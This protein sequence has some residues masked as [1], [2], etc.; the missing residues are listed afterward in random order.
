MPLRTVTH[1]LT[2]ALAQELFGA[3]KGIGDGA[4]RAQAAASMLAAV[5]LEEKAECAAGTLSGGS[6]RKLQVGIALLAD[7]HVVLLDE[8]SSGACPPFERMPLRLMSMP[9]AGKHTSQGTA[10][11][12]PCILCFTHPSHIREAHP[13]R[14]YPA[15]QGHSVGDA[16]ESASAGVDPASRQA[17]WAI[18]LASKAQRA[19]LLTTCAPCSGLFVRVLRVLG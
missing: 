3:V 18:L 8:P 14:P 5:G 10:G 7:S 2:L 4:A 13:A 17:L 11:R 16:Y 6:K 12:A 15:A 19:L 1:V 9:S